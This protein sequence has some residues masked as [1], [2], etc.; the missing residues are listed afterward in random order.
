MEKLERNENFI[1]TKFGHCFYRVNRNHTALIFNLYVIKEYRRHG[2]AKHLLKM[3]KKEI[4]FIDPYMYEYQ[5][6]AVPKENSISKED[7]I[8]FYN[9]ME[10]KI[11]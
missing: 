9:K 7:L 11:I 4:L 2:H 5:I 6:Q 1:H 10:L 3:V 8:R